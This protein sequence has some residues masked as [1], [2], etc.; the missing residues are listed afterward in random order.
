M[1]LSVTQ[2][3]SI[4]PAISRDMATKAVADS[5]T[6]KL[7]ASNGA[8]QTGVKGTAAILKL[9]QDVNLQ[10]GVGCGAR[11]PLGTTALSNG[12]ITVVRIKDE[13]NVCPDALYNSYYSYAI[14]K[15]QDPRSQGD[16][17][18]DFLRNVLELK[19]AELNL[20]VEN[21]LWNG[22]TSISGTSNLKYINGILKQ[23]AGGSPIAISEAGDTLVEKLQSV[24]LAMPVE[25]RSKSDYRIFVGT[26][27][28]DSYIVALA[29]K[30]IYKPTDDFKLFGTTATLVPVTGLNGSNKVVA[31]RI[32]NFQLGMDGD[33]EIDKV[34][35]NF[36]TETNQYYMDFRFAVGIAVIYTDQVG[37]ADFSS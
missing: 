9:S 5:Q 31:T 16:L 10:S 6:A 23:L 8:L 20:A 7:L 21:L 30:N 22:D 29:N 27:M 37:L 13:S 11:N 33:D 1:S 3:N 17:L 25:I 4:I 35:W 12:T 2:V 24:H 19:S 15:G 28:Y 32:S 18:P 36:S 14:G 26:D 34:L